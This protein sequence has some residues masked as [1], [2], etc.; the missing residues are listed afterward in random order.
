MARQAVT[1]RVENASLIS[2][3]AYNGLAF[4]LVT[5]SFL[6][7]F[8]MYSLTQ[9]GTFSQIGLFQ[10]PILLIVI[11]LVGNIGGII[12]MGVGQSKQAIPA[13]LL[14]FV[15]F[16][17]SFGITVAASLQNRG[18]P[19]VM[20]AFGITACVS[21]IFFILGL[22]YPR[23]FERIMGVVFVTF[24][25]LFVVEIVAVV[26]FHVDQTIF[27]Y[28]VIAIF[29]CFLGRDAYVL[30]SDEPTVPNAIMNAS[31]IYIDIMNIFIRV[32][33]ILDR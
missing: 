12:L 6:V 31:S 32:L 15:L 30:A 1:K 5:V 28:I 26:F 19:S 23:F 20:Y 18:L 7:M 8:G 13:S 9:N 3:R 16:S 24:L 29:C 17:L 22:L 11:S 25:A 33:D 27:D 21:G 14:G 10:N 4:G 2:R